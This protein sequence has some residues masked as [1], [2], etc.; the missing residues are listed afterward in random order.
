MVFNPGQRFNL[1]SI[2]EIKGMR[3]LYRYTRVSEHS[4]RYTI[5]NSAV[6]SVEFSKETMISSRNFYTPHRES[7]ASTRQHIYGPFDADSPFP[8]NSE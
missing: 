3:K 5:G 6:T 7:G 1:Y 4:D 8:G 2:S